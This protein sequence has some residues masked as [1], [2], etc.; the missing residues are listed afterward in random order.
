MYF[1]DRGAYE[2]YA[3]S[4]MVM[5]VS[6]T[7]SFCGCSCRNSDRCGDRSSTWCAYWWDTVVR[8]RL[9][10]A[11]VVLVELPVL[12]SPRRLY[13]LSVRIFAVPKFCE[14]YC[15]IQ[16]AAFYIRFNITGRHVITSGRLPTMQILVLIGTLGAS[17]H[18][19][20]ILPPCDFLFKTGN[21]R[22]LSIIIGVTLGEEELVEAQQLRLFHKRCNIHLCTMFWRRVY[23]VGLL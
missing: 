3:K 22:L 9:L 15:D 2:P 19:G 21:L 7:A 5:P 16:T 12:L 1:L 13:C 6:R 8:R 20:E 4:C 14:C 11:Q 18:I 10:H 17:P 23:L